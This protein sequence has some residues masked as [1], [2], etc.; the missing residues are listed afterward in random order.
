MRSSVDSFFQKKNII[1]CCTLI[2]RRPSLQQQQQQQQLDEE[3]E[4]EENYQVASKKHLPSSLRKQL[5]IR[6]L[7]ANI[8]CWV[9]CVCVCACFYVFC[10]F[11]CLRAPSQGYGLPIFSYPKKY[12]VYEIFLLC[13]SNCTVSLLL[14]HP[15]TFLSFSLYQFFV[16]SP[17]PDFH[18]KALDFLF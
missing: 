3:E 1:S 18:L 15:T 6:N 5:I 13:V 11:F 7:L 2:V 9:V 14:P 16:F 17:M 12:F 8:M 10:Q 4:D